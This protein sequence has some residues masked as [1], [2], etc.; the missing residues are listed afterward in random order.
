MDAGLRGA[1][2]VADGGQAVAGGGEQGQHQ[3]PAGPL[4]HPAVQ[5][6]AQPLGRGDTGAVEKSQELGEQAACGHVPLL[7]VRLCMEGQG[8]TY[9]MPDTRK[10][11]FMLVAVMG[12]GHLCISAYKICCLISFHCSFSFTCKCNKFPD[13]LAPIS[14]NQWLN[15]HGYS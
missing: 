5:L 14:L 6:G 4:L 11:T 15:Q 12:G 2:H 13:A 9:H 8:E 3:R 7:R 1:G 10:S